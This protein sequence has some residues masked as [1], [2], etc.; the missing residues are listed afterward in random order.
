[1][2]LQ[3]LEKKLTAKIG[4]LADRAKGKQPAGFAQELGHVLESAETPAEMLEALQHFGL[5]AVQR[6]GGFLKDEQSVA[7]LLKNVQKFAE[8]LKKLEG[9][10]R[11]LEQGRGSAAAPAAAR[12]RVRGRASATASK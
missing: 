9:L 12:R 7:S 11:S 1:M 4:K 10:G 2:V 5:E 8:A 6:L 3:K